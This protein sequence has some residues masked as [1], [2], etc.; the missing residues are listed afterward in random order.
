LPGSSPSNTIRKHPFMGSPFH[1]TLFSHHLTLTRGKTTTLQVNMGYLCNQECRHCHLKAGSDREEV[2]DGST[3]EEVIGFAKRNR[4]E[5]I[6][7]TGGA[8]EMNPNL[9]H[10]I[11]KI[12]PLTPRLMLRSNLTALQEE[13]REYL[14]GVLQG[15]RVVIIASFPSLSPAQ[16]DAQRGAGVFEKSLKVLKRLNALGY[17]KE[18]SGLE[19]D[20]VSN[21]N[22]AFLP[23]AQTQVELRFRQELMRRYGLV[24]NRL[25]TFSN[26]PVGRFRE[27]LLESGNYERYMQRLTDSFN[28]LTIENIMCRHTLSVS[29]DGY[30]YDCDFNLGLGLHLGGRKMHVSEMEG[31]PEPGTPIALSDHC[32]ACTA[33]A[34]FTCGGAI[35]T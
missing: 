7:I 2:M 29:W 11:G 34:G 28:P 1:H 10:L 14:F 15:H 8:A 5:T 12:S 22:G 19:L 16:V 9:V 27:W 4:F 6:D 21:P 26:V 25:F 31:P 3:V 13:S 30:G 35:E 18:G 24:F 17:G 33:G 32:Y 20:L 23:P